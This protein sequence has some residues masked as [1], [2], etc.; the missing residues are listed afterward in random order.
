M[1]KGGRFTNLPNH[2][3]LPVFI[4]GGLDCPNS[5][6]VCVQNGL[7][8]RIADHRRIRN[9]P[10]RSHR[11]SESILCPYDGWWRFKLYFKGLSEGVC[12][13]CSCFDRA[14]SCG[15]VFSSVRR[16]RNGETQ[17]SN[18]I[19]RNVSEMRR[20]RWDFP[21]STR[22]VFLAGIA[23]VQSW[24]ASPATTKRLSG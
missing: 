10:Q 14:M 5:Y 3:R 23:W 4:L 22:S 16:V 9:V 17:F 2:R 6:A 11:G 20:V 13:V 12:R 7:E 8:N 24:R 18:F 15:V 1:E 19:C 21:P